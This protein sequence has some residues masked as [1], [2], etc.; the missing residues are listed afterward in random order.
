[1]WG[2]GSNTIDR[3]WDSQDLQEGFGGL[4]NSDGLVV[5][6]A[7]NV[8]CQKTVQKYCQ[9]D[10]KLSVKIYTASASS[11]LDTKNFIQYCPLAHPVLWLY[12]NIYRSNPFTLTDAESLAL[13]S[14]QE[15]HDEY[16]LKHA[17]QVTDTY[18]GDPAHKLS[19]VLALEGQT[20]KRYCHQC[21]GFTCGDSPVC[22]QCKS[23]VADTLVAATAKLYVKIEGNS[24]KA[25]QMDTD[26]TQMDT[27]E[28]AQLVDETAQ[29]DAQHNK[30]KRPRRQVSLPEQ[31]KFLDVRVHRELNRWGEPVIAQ[32]QSPSKVLDSVLN[33]QIHWAVPEGRVVPLLERR[34]HPLLNLDP[35]SA[36]GQKAICKSFA[37]RIRKSPLQATQRTVITVPVGTAIPAGGSIIHDLTGSA[38]GT[39]QVAFDLPVGS[40]RV[41]LGM[42]VDGGL[43]NGIAKMCS[44]DSE[45]QNIVLI[46]PAF[47]NRK[48]CLETMNKVSEHLGYKVMVEIH[49]QS[50]NPIAVAK[51][52][53]VTNPF[54]KPWQ[55][56]RVWWEICMEDLMFTYIRCS[57]NGVRTSA[58]FREWVASHDATEYEGWRFYA[59]WISVACM[60]LIHQFTGCRTGWSDLFTAALKRSSVNTFAFHNVKYQAL[61]YTALRTLEAARSYSAEVHDSL[62]QST[63]FSESHREQSNEGPDGNMEHVIELIKSWGLTGQPEQKIMQA[64]AHC[65]DLKE[66]ESSLHE[67]LGCPKRQSEFNARAEYVG[68]R[69]KFRLHLQQ[70]KTS[71]PRKGSLQQLFP[72][73]DSSIL[74]W[75]SVGEAAMASYHT[76]FVDNG[77]KQPTA[78]KWKPPTSIYLNAEARAKAEQ[79]CKKGKDELLAKQSELR[80][81][82]KELKVD[83]H[84]VAAAVWDKKKQADS[85][86]LIGVE[87]EALLELLD[88]YKLSQAPEVPNASDGLEEAIR[89]VVDDEGNNLEHDK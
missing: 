83:T 4:T 59:D 54:H 80:D 27:D 69:S 76:A 7:D 13:R 84:S 30:L 31:V 10:H 45:F 71:E 47:H 8:G 36:A 67:F 58:G 5:V 44:K 66:L 82:L 81:L 46:S 52:L 34:S 25:A 68:E 16:F 87:V 64:A 20:G 70:T 77:C 11:N 88:K 49:M 40:P 12:S 41:L 38:A 22:A 19:L 18:G 15:K 55:C 37:D 89:I 42:G 17:V 53:T 65:T 26:E 33:P 23:K 9:A 57:P 51:M 63:S 3:Y 14:E 86:H 29:V 56:F 50:K 73:L 32:N 75:R 6:A 78:S 2:G 21:Q 28:A 60:D 35:G 48:L 1:M 72:G 74:D 62:L 43:F 24:G 61:N 79:W 85:K 39:Q